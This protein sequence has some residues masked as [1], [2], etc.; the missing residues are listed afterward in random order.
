MVDAVDKKVTWDSELKQRYDRLRKELTDVWGPE[1]IDDKIEI[2][3]V[4]LDWKFAEFL[5][6]NE[7]YLTNL[8]TYV[9]TIK[10]DGL[11]KKAWAS[12]NDLKAFLD[13][14]WD[15]GGMEKDYNKL[16]DKLKNPKDLHKIKDK[17]LRKLTLYLSMNENAA[18]EAY[19]SM[20]GF[21][22]VD[23][24]FW[25]ATLS[26]TG[27]KLEDINVFQTIWKTIKDNYQNNETFI[28]AT[29]PGFKN[30]SA[31]SQ[32]IK[33]FLET[34]KWQISWQW[35]EWEWDDLTVAHIGDVKN[36]IVNKEAVVAKL[37]EL[38]NQRI[39]KNKKLVETVSVNLPTTSFTKT[40][41]WWLKYNWNEFKADDVLMFV[42]E[43][44]AAVTGGDFV[45]DREKSRLI[46]ESKDKIYNNLKNKLLSD[47]NVKVEDVSKDGKINTKDT[48]KNNTTNNTTDNTKNN[49]DKNN[50]KTNKDNSKPKNK[51]N[52]TP[53]NVENKNVGVEYVVGKNLIKINDAGLKDKIK[54]LWFCGNL[55]KKLVNFNISK[56]REYLTSFQDMTWLK[57]QVQKPLDKKA[58]IVAVQIALN[59]LRIKDKK[60]KS[61]A[62]LFINWTLSPATVNWIKSF[63]KVNGLKVDG[64]LWSN[65]IRKFVDCL[66]WNNG[67]KQKPK[68]W[69]VNLPDIDY[70]TVEQTEKNNKTETEKQNNKNNN[71]VKDE[72]KQVNNIRENESNQNV[73]EVGT[74][75]KNSST[76][77]IN[78]GGDN[79]GAIFGDL[80]SNVVINN[81]NIKSGKS[82]DNA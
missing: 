18:L 44:S 80:T 69:K 73:V 54:E 68:K 22:D 61:S 52:R 76:V 2:D 75:I 53:K 65:T 48:D 1:T 62:R 29:Y 6:K 34:Y 38:N 47:P 63:Q 71:Q 8:K 11:E 9:D 24:W 58:L 33:S 3:D 19:R 25:S 37:N 82:W 70:I 10:R 35:L 28:E 42:H 51:K 17:E 57:L 77:S 36:S 12:V 43:I 26:G 50:D 81:S 60:Q 74:S 41:E 66:W 78:V 39:S 4:I 67:W 56:V 72:A 30:L 27:M 31:N 49:T 46:R 79:N 45:N 15:K 13:D 16:M 23:R 59:Y 21:V 55:D 7:V 40:P 20:K 14:L 5:L 32:S 64:R